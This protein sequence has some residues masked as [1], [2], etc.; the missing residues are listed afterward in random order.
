[1]Q[2]LN[3]IQ[4]SSILVLI[5]L[6]WSMLWKGIA[7]WKAAN[8]KQRNWFVVVLVLNTMGILEIIYLFKFARQKMIFSDLKFW[9][10]KTQ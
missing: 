2:Y 3:Q 1:M 9:R 7:L 4:E 10:S 8:Y 5:I 6:M